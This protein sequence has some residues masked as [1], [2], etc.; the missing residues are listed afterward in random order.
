MIEDLLGEPP[1]YALIGDVVGR[2]PY[3]W[4]FIVL[5]AYK[6]YHARVCLCARLHLR[7]RKRVCVR[8]RVYMCAYEMRPKKPSNF[9][10]RGNPSTLLLKN[11]ESFWTLQENTENSILSFQQRLFTKTIFWPTIPYCRLCDST[12]TCRNMIIL[13]QSLNLLMVWYP[14]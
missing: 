9:H 2:W 8:A 6:L 14:L 13:V 3:R 12:D 7:M 11:S 5:S 1:I 4:D 10:L